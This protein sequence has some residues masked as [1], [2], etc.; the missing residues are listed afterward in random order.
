MIEVSIDQ[1]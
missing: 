1:N